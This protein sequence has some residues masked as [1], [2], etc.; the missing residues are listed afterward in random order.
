M[1]TKRNNGST[2][3]P[4]KV[5]RPIKPIK[6]QNINRTVSSGIQ[7]QALNDLIRK[8]IKQFGQI[9]VNDQHVKHRLAKKRRKSMAVKFIK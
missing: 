1:K 3:G 5:P 6:I 8:T 7:K 2:S 4:S 9:K